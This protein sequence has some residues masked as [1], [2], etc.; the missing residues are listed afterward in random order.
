MRRSRLSR[1]ARRLSLRNGNLKKEISTQLAVLPTERVVKYAS[2]SESRASVDPVLA[3]MRAA[4]V[5]ELAQRQQLAQIE[6]KGVQPPKTTD[7]KAGIRKFAEFA[8]KGAQFGAKALSGEL[9]TEFQEGI[10]TIGMKPEAK[11]KFL[12]AERKEAAKAEAEEEDVW[13]IVA[14]GSMEWQEER[15]EM[16]RE[17]EKAFGHRK[18]I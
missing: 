16:L 6:R 10:A 7:R 11:K 4:A 2:I 14:K 9:A 3:S 8:R 17:Q 15:D 1:S 12:E 18:R 13:D 5:S